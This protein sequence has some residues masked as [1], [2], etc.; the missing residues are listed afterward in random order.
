MQNG[1]QKDNMMFKLHSKATW[2]VHTF[3]WPSIKM[4]G[5]LSR[6]AKLNLVFDLFSVTI[7]LA[8]IRYP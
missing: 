7:N 2:A 8:K 4:Q 1:S 6:M 3:Q 5:M